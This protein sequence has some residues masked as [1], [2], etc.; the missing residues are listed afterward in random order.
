[1]A[2]VKRGR[3]VVDA[4]G[5]VADPHTGSAVSAETLLYAASTGKGVASS[6]AHVLVERGALDH[7]VRIVEVWPEF[8]AHG[9][10]SVTLRHVLLH[11]AG[12]PGLPGDITIANLCDWDHMCAIIAD[13]RP[14]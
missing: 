11:T 9:K 10:E 4:V 13:E 5:G 14:W 12:V 1:V 6:I 8:G 2:V 3:V 7:D